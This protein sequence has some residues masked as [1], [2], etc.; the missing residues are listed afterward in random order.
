VALP[1]TTVDAFADRPFEGNP[2]AV[3][4]LGDAALD[5]DVLQALAAEL[6]LSET[7]FV[8]PRAD[9]DWDLRWFTPNT[10][11]DLCGHA[12]LAA[13]HVLSQKHAGPFRFH[14]LSGVLTCKDG[15]FA[16]HRMDFP[17]TPARPCPP[18]PGLMSALGIGG[19]AAC[20]QSRFDLLIELSSAA[21]VEAITPN[22]AALARIPVRGVM[23]TAPGDGT[24]ADFVSRFFAPR[25]GVPEDPVTGSAHCAL[26]PWWTE[27]LGS[28]RL[29]A[30]QL[31]RRGGSLYV[32]VDG[33]RVVLEGNAVV[34]IA[35]SIDPGV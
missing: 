16:Q 29:R 23:V 10:E 25:V 24:D 35:G 9:G 34:V 7:A 22:M 20:G 31:S 17:A 14:T 3:I 2:A 18:P 19:I 6:G 11:V 33:D 4:E 21:A 15:H 1:L 32:R 30:R 28:N 5:D 13:A 27:R 12:T 26:G 8:A